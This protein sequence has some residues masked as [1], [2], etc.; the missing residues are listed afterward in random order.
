MIQINDIWRYSRP[1]PV[2]VLDSATE[3]LVSG[4]VSYI[5]SIG[6]YGG[7]QRKIVASIDRSSGNITSI[8]DYSIY[9]G[10]D[11]IK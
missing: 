1:D 6:F 2:P 8:L 9:S 7:V 3:P 10:S 5:E 11:L 4:P